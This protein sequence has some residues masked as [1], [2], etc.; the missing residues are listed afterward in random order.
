MHQGLD[1]YIK[2][3]CCDAMLV[4]LLCPLRLF[5]GRL[6][7]SG[8]SKGN[9]LVSSWDDSRADYSC[10]SGMDGLPQVTLLGPLWS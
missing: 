5:S 1:S 6:P 7:V 4:T 3:A 10:V 2:V 8:L 9:D